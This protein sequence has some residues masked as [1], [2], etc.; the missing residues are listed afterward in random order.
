[1]YKL[2]KKVM[3][4]ILATIM[5]FSLSVICVAT[6]AQSA[7]LQ[8]ASVITEQLEEAVLAENIS[9]VQSM[10][11]KLQYLEN[12]LAA[13]N[14]SVTAAKIQTLIDAT[15]NLTAAYIA[16]QN[17]GSLST[18]S[19]TSTF[20]LYDPSIAL[21][22]SYFGAQGYVLADELLLY[23]QSNTVLDTKYIPINVWA[24]RE[25]LQW[26]TIRNSPAESGTG[27]F[28]NEGNTVERDLYYAVHGFSWWREQKGSQRLLIFSDRYDFEPGDY[29]N[30]EGIAVNTM[31]LAQLNGD[32][33]PFYTYYQE[34]SA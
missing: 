8:T 20:G 16:Y 7:R 4:C 1:M 25:S 6:D 24:I 2:C 34:Y 32:L 12:L 9:V 11:D 14:D 19:T 15:K 28:E 21:V 31:Y 5:A 17:Q 13:T 30:I 23:A 26:R 18:Y 10:N 29:S 33:T 27:V 3:C 22:S